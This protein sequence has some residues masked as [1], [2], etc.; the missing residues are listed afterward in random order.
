M[1]VVVGASK[2]I[3]A[4]IS[5]QLA[6]ETWTVAAIARDWNALDKLTEEIDA[7]VYVADATDEAQIQEAAEMITVNHKRVDALIYN[8]GRGL[9]KSFDEASTEEIRDLFEVNYFGALTCMAA[10][11]FG[12]IAA[13]VDKDT[14]APPHIIN[15]ASASATNGYPFGAAYSASK[16]A[17][18]ATTR[19]RVVRYDEMGIRISGMLPGFADTDGFPQGTL[20]EYFRRLMMTTPEHVAKQVANRLNKKSAIEHIPHRYWLGALATTAMP[21]RSA[22]LTHRLLGDY[23]PRT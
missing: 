6:E 21:M 5:R 11:E 20:P 2:G 13:A 3:G 19:D 15:I 22:K 8:A 12:L 4:A 16:A 9:D 10:F 1:A 7:D 17:L 18:Y 14:D 23:H